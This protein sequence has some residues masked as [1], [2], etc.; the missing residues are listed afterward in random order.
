MCA[1]LFLAA[2]RLASPF[3]DGAVLQRETKVPVW[4]TAEGGEIV[5][6]TFAEQHLVT[7]ASAEGRWRVDLAPM[8]ASG[9]GRDLRANGACARDVVVGEVWLCSGQ[10]NMAVPWWGDSPRARER[11]GF[12]V[13]QFVSRPLLRCAVLGNGWS[14]LPL[15]EEDVRWRS[16]TPDFLL[17]G[18]FSAVALW[19]GLA[20]QGALEIPVGLLGAY[21]GGPD[22]ETWTP[23]CK[24][25]PPPARANKDGQRP[26]QFHNGKI[27]PILPYAIKGVIWY[28]GCNNA[29]QLHYLPLHKALIADWRAKMRELHAGWK[30]AFE[31]PHLK[32]YFCQLCPWGDPLVPLMQEAQADFARSERDAAM[33][34]LCDVGNIHDIHPNDK[35]TPGLRLAALALKRDYGFEK[36]VADSPTLKS[37]KVEDGKFRLSFL[38]VKEWFVYDP[39]WRHVRD[40]R[41]SEDYGFEVAGSD[42]KWKKAQIGNFIRVS[43]VSQ[44]E[45]RGQISNVVLEVFS[46]GVQ[47]PEA[48]RYLHSAPWR[49]FLFNEA[50][51]PLGAFHIG[52][53]A[54]CKDLTVVK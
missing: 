31:N 46:P 34:V 27:A 29:G 10:S 50:G 8:E 53:D 3:T 1:S 4:G 17:R 54:K 42:G 21:A 6:V 23:D 14:D 26:S 35:Q 28:Q 25:L 41:R 2:V 52:T 45:Y 19:Y 38:D 39:E 44:V 11:L 9:I 37:W 12:Q 22:I 48:L 24:T 16:C 47:E 13:G 7:R 36:I 5:S 15:T 40:P 33:V 32:F 51:L 20:L 49:G 30:R 18:G 43:N